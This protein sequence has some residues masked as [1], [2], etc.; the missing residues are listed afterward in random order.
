MRGANE[1]IGREMSA[2]EVLNE[3]LKD[4]M[5]Y[6]TSGGGLTVTGGEPSFQPEFTLELLRLA[7]ESGISIAVETCG[8]GSRGFYEK[9]SELGTTFLFDLKCMDSDRHREF[10]GS[11]NSHIISNLLFLMDKGADIIIRLPLI[12]GCN[13]SDKDIS[14]IS[15]FLTENIARYRYA[16][17]MPYHSLGVGKAEKTGVT[18]SY[19]HANATNDEISRWCSL[20]E[21]HGINIKVSDK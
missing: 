18:A 7:K 8:I 1:I 20:F 19:V 16:E 9:A 4:R 17:I 2:A 12:P 13:D 15:A 5:F 10:T 11:D 3:V 14:D 6:E 21:H